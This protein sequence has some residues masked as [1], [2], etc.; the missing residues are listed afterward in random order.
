[1][2][3]AVCLTAYAVLLALAVWAVE[4]IPSAAFALAACGGSLS[5]G[6][7]ARLRRT[8]LATFDWR[9]ASD[10]V[11]L[12]GAALL[13]GTAAAL[14]GG[15]PLAVVGVGLAGGTFVASLF[16][17]LTSGRPAEELEARCSS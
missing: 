15:P 11:V 5:L 3:V 7:V 17:Q 16:A 12:V 6:A 9:L 2:L 10:V 8:E 1:M 13:I 4:D 14:R